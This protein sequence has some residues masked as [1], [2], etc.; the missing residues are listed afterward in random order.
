M[1]NA[2][3]SAGCSLVTSNAGRPYRRSTQIEWE[4]R[5]ETERHNIHPISKYSR[6]PSPVSDHFSQQVKQAERG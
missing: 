1:A 3:N 5:P 4:T 6:R 2:T